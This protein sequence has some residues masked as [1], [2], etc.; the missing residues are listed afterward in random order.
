MEQI[1]DL[2]CRDI[3]ERAKKGFKKYGRR[4]KD[5]EDDM[6]QHAYEEVLDLANYLKAQIIK[7]SLE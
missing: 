1:E 7:G 6:L 4:L 2:V 5:S 3:Q